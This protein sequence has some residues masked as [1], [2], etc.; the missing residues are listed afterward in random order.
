VGF[1]KIILARELDLAQIRAIRAQVDRA[2]LEFFIHGALCV[3]YSGQCFISHAHTGRSAN[4]GN[5]SQECR[6]PYKVT[7]AQ[8]G[9][10]AHEKHVLSIK[11][12]DQS[13]NL[14]VVVDAG[15]RSFKIEGRYK[16]MGTVKNVTAH[17]RRLIDQLLE[18]RP[19]MKASSSGRT[20]FLFT[21]DPQR[22]FNRGGTD[23][24][25][26]GRRDDLGAFD[27]PK[28]AGTPIGHVTRVAKASFDVELA[29]DDT[30]LSNGDGLTYYDLQ[31]EL[32]GVQVNTAEP[33]GGRAWRVVPNEPVE[34][35]KD[36]RVDTLLN[37][38][39]DMN[40]ERVLAR[41]SSQRRIAVRIHFHET[42]T[43]FALELVDT[44]GIRARAEIAHAKQPAHD[45]GKSDASIR[46]HLGKLGNTIFNASRIDIQF[47]QPWFVPASALN[48]LRRDA[49][50]ALES[51]RASALQRPPRATPVDPP[52]PYPADALS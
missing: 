1:S 17:Y 19:A 35:L 30:S 20:T 46:E 51:A 21:P 14:G 23:Y 29:D 33:V 32:V 28:H 26:N 12:N 7:D 38:N 11:D 9:I 52:A 25:V 49:V 40:W 24:F 39:R 41:R 44:V 36:L 8:G 48:A 3:A 34:A 27:T 15:V 16:D 5:C 47:A 42:R 18:G 6:L 2:K 22:N 4:R 43:G 50:H 13:A 10:I 31:Q 37:R 45:A